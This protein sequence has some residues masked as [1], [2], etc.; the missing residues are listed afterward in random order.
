MLRSMAASSGIMAVLVLALYVNSPDITQLYHRPAALWAVCPI[1]PFWVSR[2]LMLSNRGLMP[3]DPVVFA[4]RDRISL[5]VG[6]GGLRRFQ[7]LRL[8]LGRRCPDRHIHLVNVQLQRRRP[9]QFV[10][11]RSAG[12]VDGV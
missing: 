6:A 9:G 11:H 3:D 7:I 5:L 2:V 8:D 12:E 1:L 4:L 10:D